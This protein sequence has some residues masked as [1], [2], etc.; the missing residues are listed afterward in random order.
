MI[1]S[2]A[3]LKRIDDISSLCPTPVLMLKGSEISSRNLTLELVSAGLF[4]DVW[5]IFDDISSLIV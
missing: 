4:N 1:F 2:K 5:D 3:Q